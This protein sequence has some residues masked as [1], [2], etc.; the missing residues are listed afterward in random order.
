M[1]RTGMQSPIGPFLHN[2]LSILKDLGDAVRDW[3]MHYGPRVAVGVAALYI[4]ILAARLVVLRLRHRR[5]A[6]GART[7]EIMPPPEVAMTG[8]ETLW[9]TMLGLLRPA[10]SRLLFGQPHLAFEYDADRDGVRIRIWIPGT[11]PPGLVERAIEA[12]WPGTHTATHYGATPE[13]PGQVTGGT[14]RLARPDHHPLRTRFTDDPVRGLLAA[15]GHLDDGERVLIQVLARPITGRRLNQANRAA[16]VLRGDTPPTDLKGSLFDLLTPTRRTPSRRAPV[17]PDVPGEVRAIVDKA[18]QPRLETLIRYATAT[19]ADTPETRAWRRGRAHALASAFAVFTG[20]NHLLRRRTRY[21]ESAIA[22]RRMGHGDLLSVAELAAIAHLPTDDAI[23]GIDRA[24]AR[25]VAPSSAISTGGPDTRLLGESD[26]G[27]ARPIALR[28]PDGRHH[29][30]VV[31]SNGVGK[32]TSLLNWAL[33]DATAQ[34]GFLFMEP[35]GE[36]TMLL[37]R[38]PADAADRVVLFDPDDAGRPPSLNVLDGPNPDLTVDT[39]VGIFRRIYADF[40]GPRTDDVLRSA[41]LTLAGRDGA[42]LGDVSRLLSDDTYRRRTTA[43]LTNPELRTFWS[44]YDSLSDGT[45]SQVVGPV[46]NKLRTV[47]LRGF[48]RDILASGP[49]TVDLA[50]TFDTG[51]IV[52]ARLPKGV[53]GE[54]TARLLGSLILAKTWQAILG[55]AQVPASQRPDITL[56]LDEAQNFLTLPHGVDDMLAEARAYRAGLV[57]AHQHLAQLPR[58]TREAVS[59]NAR[60]KIIFAVSPE[61]ARDLQRHVHP[62][63]DA[64]DL[65]HLDAFQAAARLMAGHALTPACTVRTRSLPPP[66]KGRATQIRKAARANYGARRGAQPPQARRPDDPRAVPPTS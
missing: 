18:A 40:W 42:T 32:T 50:H 45:R 2:P 52:I 41:C 64:H 19:S 37:S 62:A 8:A 7:I 9:A 6:R 29:C 1:I 63:L 16:A 12:A 59:S 30:Q 26:A 58:D 13:L 20:P 46:M 14:L 36:S 44:W 11:V 34:R 65:A 5:F 55:R 10:W 33:D 21:I 31:G 57:L 4:G 39:I 15:A 25:R 38:L 48:A 24:P 22:D 61:D 35:K 17:L 47:L 43:G 53:L 49:S 54:D 56:Y 60:N 3:A 23:P 28:V 51:G 66:V 27:R